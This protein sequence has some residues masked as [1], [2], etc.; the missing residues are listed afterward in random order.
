MPFVLS[1]AFSILL[2]ESS[3][4]PTAAGVLRHEFFHFD[5][6][7]LPADRANT[8]S[9]TQ[10]AVTLTTP[11]A[12][13]QGVLRNMSPDRASTQSATLGAGSPCPGAKKELKLLHVAQ[14]P[15][16]V[17]DALVRLREVN[18]H[19]E[20]A[21]LEAYVNGVSALGS[22]RNNFLFHYILAC[23]KYPSFVSTFAPKLAKLP[24]SFSTSDLYTV[25]AQGAIEWSKTNNLPQQQEEMLIYND[26][27]MGTMMGATKLF[28]KLGVL[29]KYQ[30]PKRK[31]RITTK[32]SPA[33][34]RDIL[35]LGRG[36]PALRYQL[37]G[38]HNALKVF[39]N[40]LGSTTITIDPV[41][42]TLESLLALCKTWTHAL[43]DLEKALVASR[44]APKSDKR[45]PVKLCP[46]PAAYNAEINWHKVPYLH[47][48][49]VRKTSLWLIRQHTQQ[50]TCCID[51]NTMTPQDLKIIAPDQ[52]SQLDQLPHTGPGC[53]SEA[54]TKT[55]QN[56][57]LLT[58]GLCLMQ[59]LFDKKYQT[60]LQILMHPDNHLGLMQTI[61]EYKAKFNMPPTYYRLAMLWKAHFMDDEAEDIQHDEEQ[62]D[63]CENC[64][65]NVLTAG[66]M[67]LDKAS[68][69]ASDPEGVQKKKASPKPG[70]QHAINTEP[71]RWYQIQGPGTRCRCKS[72]NC[73]LGCPSRLMKGHCGNPASINISKADKQKKFWIP[74]CDACRCQ[75]EGCHASARRPYGI[76]QKP[77]NNGFCQKHWSS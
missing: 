71:R 64:E 37:T 45:V 10:G 9:P 36:A 58:C 50:G 51:F 33:P 44:I 74:L 73:V 55:N 27:R 8:S 28:E 23:G 32:S 1:L 2:Q 3:S 70:E 41:E 68:P 47:K 21:D 66:S 69:T 14:L 12:S 76:H 57:L 22:H 43:K 4:R 34:G 72:G 20:P 48:H 13:I 75:H 60:L 59:K 39:V 25:L 24:K 54:A 5:Q 62:Q 65:N 31:F 67:K 52:T 49:I 29:V 53:I 26:Q 38:K 30:P 17:F 11:K 19:L 42:L 61:Q 15:E 6:E 18:P 16:T 35:A 56:P 77:E 40:S 7:S 63:F 46:K